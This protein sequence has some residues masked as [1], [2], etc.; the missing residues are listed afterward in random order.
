VQFIATF[1]SDVRVPPNSDDCRK[2]KAFSI[3]LRAFGTLKAH[4]QSPLARMNLIPRFS[5]LFT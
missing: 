2:G 1:L 5:S 3:V 4:I